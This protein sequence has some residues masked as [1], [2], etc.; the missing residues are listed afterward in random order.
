MCVESIK[1]G[2]PAPAKR[3]SGV[4]VRLEENES[5]RHEPRGNKE[6]GPVELNPPQNSVRPQVT[7]LARP[8]T[9]LASSRRKKERKRTSFDILVESPRGGVIEG[10]VGRS[11]GSESEGRDEVLHSCV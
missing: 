5:K 8:T 3:A 2:A 10:E 6:R 1:M 9:R 4:R 7:P 11:D